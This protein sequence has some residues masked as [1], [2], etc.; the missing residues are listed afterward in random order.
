MQKKHLAAMIRSSAAKNSSFVALRIKESGEWKE[1]TYK[2]MAELIDALSLALIDMGVKEGKTVGI[3][4]PNRPEWSI[5]DF[6]IL[7]VGAITV[8]IY[9]TNTSKQAEYIVDH[10]E[11][12]TLFVASS[13]QYDKIQTFQ[14]KS[15]KLKK[16]I[17]IDRSIKLEGDESI[18][19][20]D[21]IALGKKSKSQN[22]LKK[23]LEKGKPSDLATII[24]TSG[25]TGPPKGAMLTH[26]NFYHQIDGINEHFDIT[27]ADRSLC[28]LPLSHAYERA[29]CFLVF[30]A[31][32]QVN[33]LSD[34]K[35]IVETMPD[36]RPTAMISVPRLYEK[37]YTTAFAKLGKA[38][39]AKQKM[40]MWAVAKGKKY[41]YKKKDG[42]FRGPWLRFTH[43]LA[44]KLVLT[45]IRDIVGGPK[46][47]FSA[48][49][50]SLAKEIE[51]FFYAAGLLVCQGYGLTETS[52]V[53]TCNRPGDYK[54]GTVGKV[55][56][57]T[58]VKIADNGEILTRG[59]NLM[60][61]YYK[62][63]E[64]TAKAI[65]DGWFHTGDVG[66]IDSEGFVRI[67]D[68]IKDIMITAQGKNVAPL[69]IES[70]I[71][72]DYFIEQVMVVG[73][74]RPY[75]AG[76]VIPNFE[77]LEEYA[78][79]KGITWTS[80]EDLISK[81]EI[82]SFYKARID[83]ASVELAGYE[84]IKRFK[85]MPQEFSQETG[86]LTPTLKMK[87][88]NILEKYKAIIDEIYA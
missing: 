13:E 32:A 70:V 1:T 61:G 74:K 14:K 47:F 27:T 7:S 6:A 36:A 45:K 81:P 69:Q 11:L 65:V 62:Q 18:Y 57:D 56:S 84:Q 43:A 64:E 22:E 85:L 20:D 38:S 28:F 19:F 17:V 21:V 82:I 49:G 2:E 86:E 39:P 60:M 35:L 30:N 67:T 79:E 55:L 52:P 8:P 25:T 4:S 41:Q 80:R 87:R 12:T 23:R 71:G 72:L 73:E 78:K 33:Y 68:R 46:N 16:I 66:E 15:K 34:T 24:Y 48:G 9:A 63:P 3:F 51:E 26:S 31:G 50:G 75:L 54:F 58:E 83:E 42:E 37:I 59:G 40:F 44:D 29:W 76:L 10:A 53:V 5:S 77:A 88:K